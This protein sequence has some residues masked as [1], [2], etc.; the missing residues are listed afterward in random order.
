MT[1]GHVPTS[2]PQPIV[3][4]YTM[5]PAWLACGGRGA[6]TVTYVVLDF[7]ASCTLVAVTVAVVVYDG[8]VKNPD[9]TF[10]QI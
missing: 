2:H 9:E 3:S 7:D 8:A 1:L 10:T 4:L 6:V 5:L